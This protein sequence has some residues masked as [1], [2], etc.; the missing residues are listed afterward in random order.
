MNVSSPPGPAS[1]TA[2]MN[3]YMFIP[4]PERQR[5][6]EGRGFGLQWSRVMGQNFVPS[7]LWSLQ[8]LLTSVFDRCSQLNAFNFN[9]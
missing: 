1:M 6:G 3:K 4:E 2:D 5:I 9:F 8:N 7:M